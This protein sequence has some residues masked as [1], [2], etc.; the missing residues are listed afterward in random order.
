LIEVLPPLVLAVVVA[1]VVALQAAASA[2][3]AATAA[4]RIAATASRGV[5]D[6]LTVTVSGS[7]L[8]Q[9]GC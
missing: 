2:A 7:S 5:R 9:P 6:P 4:M 1:V 8:A 3:S